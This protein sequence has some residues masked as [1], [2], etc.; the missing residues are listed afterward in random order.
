MAEQIDLAAPVGPTTNVWRIKTLTL[1]Q[2]LA[3]EAGPIANDP[4]KSV[5]RVVL[6]GLN[7]KTLSHN[8]EGAGADAD[9]VS[10]N[11]LNLSTTSL[12]KRIFNKLIAD[13]VIV[14]TISGAPD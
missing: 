9:I 4:T 7:G 3:S 2:G 5:I 10:F 1:D 8:W 6:L 12:Q 14:G 13:G 11:K